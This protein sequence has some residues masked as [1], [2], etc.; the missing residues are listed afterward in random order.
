MEGNPN[1]SNVNPLPAVRW[2]LVT[3]LRKC[4]WLRLWWQLVTAESV[5]GGDCLEFV[6]GWYIGSV[7]RFALVMNPDLDPRWVLVGRNCTGN[8]LVEACK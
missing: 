6:C 2:Q 3:A 1:I 5:I 7:C 4:Y 8:S